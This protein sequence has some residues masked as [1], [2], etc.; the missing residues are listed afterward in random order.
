MSK[1]VG[2]VV[3]VMDTP[4]DMFGKLMSVSD[5]LMWRYYELLSFQP[6][7]QLLPRR[8]EFAG[9][10]PRDEKVILAKELVA[11]FHDESCAKKQKK[12]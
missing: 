9:G 6:M 4:D 7:E 2:N 8:R 1:S 5:D 12:L 3:S 11:R 10:N